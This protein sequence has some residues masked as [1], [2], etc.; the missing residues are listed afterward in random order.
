MEIS[1]VVLVDD[2]GRETGRM[3]KLEAHQRGLLHRAFSAFVVNEKGEMLLQQRAA[4]KYHSPDLWTNACCS[5]PFPGETVLAAATRRL[6][7]ELGFSCELE[8]FDFLKYFARFDNGLIEH[9]YDHLLVGRYD[10]GV[11]PNI[12]EVQDFKFVPLPEIE[13]RLR[14]EPERFTF[15]FRLAYP[16]VREYLRSNK[17]LAVVV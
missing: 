5:H 4:Q 14:I 6:D 1:E 12:E 15:W 7:E 8:E 3:E 13:Q 9:E 17:P 10:G 2:D 16:L 11:S